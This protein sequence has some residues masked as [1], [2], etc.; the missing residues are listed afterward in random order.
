MMVVLP[1]VAFFSPL[2]PSPAGQQN[3][4]LLVI[5]GGSGGLACAKEGKHLMFCVCWHGHASR[6]QVPP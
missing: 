3:Y 2:I 4:D 5:G 1:G 6:P